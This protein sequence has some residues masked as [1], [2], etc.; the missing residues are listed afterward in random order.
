M[1]TP[2]EQPHYDVATTMSNTGEKYED[3]DGFQ[4]QYVPTGVGIALD[5]PG[6][7]GA[8]RDTMRTNP[9]P[10]PVENPMF[11]TM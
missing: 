8:R 5:G 7:G 10:P 1:T 11:E 9:N 2:G 6:G 3:L 4:Q